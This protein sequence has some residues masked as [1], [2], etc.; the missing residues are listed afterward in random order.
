[1]EYLESSVDG[2]RLVPSFMDHQSLNK[3]EAETQ[4]DVLDSELKVLQE[5]I[6]DLISDIRD[7]EKAASL[8]DLN[9]VSEEGVT[10][11]RL[12]TGQVLASIE[13]VPTVPHCT[14]ASIIG[15][16]IRSKL[17]Q[18][19]PQKPKIDIFIKKGTHDTADEIN[20]Q[21]NDKER[22]SAAMENP[23]LQKLVA[24]CTDPEAME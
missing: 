8:E 22:I 23:N 9:V 24:S 1:M 2:E 18:S 12:L 11:R 14:L 19:L 15:L 5:T 10:V 17:D 7:P 13:F 21:I 16:S 20:K 3:F 4:P 6:Y